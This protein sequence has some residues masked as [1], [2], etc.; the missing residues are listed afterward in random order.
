MPDLGDRARQRWVV[1]A[2]L[3][4]LLASLTVSTGGRDEPAHAAGDCGPGDT[5]RALLT[6]AGGKTF[7]PCLAKVNIAIDIPRTQTSSLG[8][9]PFFLRPC[10]SGK[11]RITGVQRSGLQTVRYL[12]GS[13]EQLY[14]LTFRQFQ[15]YNSLSMTTE[16]IPGGPVPGYTMRLLPDAA[17]KLGGTSSSGGPVFTDMWVT[18]SSVIHLDFSFLG[19]GFTCDENL[20]VDN[21]ILGVTS[22]IAI[23]SDGCGMNLDARYIVTTAGTGDLTGQYAVNLPNSRILI[24]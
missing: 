18:P 15:V 13:T 12:D 19:V 11:W 8:C 22:F 1:L 5:H 14:R 24:D 9:G 3:V 16:Q 2:A 17:A 20:R 7:R 6:T 4:V 21:G 23:S 10:F